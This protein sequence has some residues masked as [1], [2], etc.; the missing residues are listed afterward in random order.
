MCYDEFSVFIFYIQ[1]GKS[2]KY[3]KSQWIISEL[4]WII[5]LMK[6]N[7]QNWSYSYFM[8]L[9][10]GDNILYYRKCNRMYVSTTVVAICTICRRGRQRK[11]NTK[12]LWGSFILLIRISKNNTKGQRVILG[13]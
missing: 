3:W 2:S 12:T 4:L 13:G 9:K 6:I 1:I 7:V 10:E 11:Q 5:G 8:E